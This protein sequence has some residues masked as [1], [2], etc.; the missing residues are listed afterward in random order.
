[1]NYPTK[2]FI[3]VGGAY[4]VMDVDGHYNAHYNELGIRVKRLIY[5]HFR[6]TF[7]RYAAPEEIKEES[8]MHKYDGAME[9]KGYYGSKGY[10]EENNGL[11][12]GKVMGIDASVSYEAD[13]LDELREAFEDA[14]D[15]YISYLLEC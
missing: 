12:Y 4:C 14:V 6:R 3:S 10:T 13:S 8:Y 5:S 2:P 7:F 11:F 1:M 9:H 15:G